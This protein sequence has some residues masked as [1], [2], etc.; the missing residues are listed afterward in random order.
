M[1]ALDTV[2][3]AFDRAFPAALNPWRNLGGVAFLLFWIVAAT[4]IYVYIGFD[5]QADGAYA[6]VERLADGALPLAALARS[7]HRYASD[8]F[9]LVV[10][11]HVVRECVRGRYRHFRRFSWIT[12]IVALW[13]AFASGLGGFWLVWDETAQYS[14]TATLEWLDAL[15]VFGGALVRNVLAG[16]AVSDR[17][18]SLLVFLHIG[19]PLTLLAAMWIHLLRVATP[20]SIAPRALTFGT[21][22]ALVVLAV[23]RPVTSAAPADMA[24]IPG[25][26]ALDWFYLGVHAFADATSP[27][28]LWAIAAGGTLLLL[29]L[30]WMTRVPRPAPARVDLSRC[31]G[32]A[33]C[34]DDC[35][36]LAITMAPRSD[37]RSL[38]A[39]AVVAGDLCAACGICAGSCSS[40]GIDLPD[41]PIARVRTELDA[42]LA[43]LRVSTADGARVI[44]FGCPTQRGGADLAHFGDERTATVALECAGQLP[45]SLVD[46]ALRAGADGVVVAGCRGGD[47]EFRLGNQWAE[48]RVTRRRAPKVRRGAWPSRVRTAW[49]GRGGESALRVA[50]AEF[51]TDL[52]LRSPQ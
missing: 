38:P 3:I 39:Q 10:V 16:G 37:G 48:A 14:F 49:A 5:T 31:N 12:G 26:I 50:L 2:E 27:A 20:R 13:L 35:P 45:A 22:A 51:R 11:L 40:T 19:I 42:A 7:L 18:F 1:N 9:I 23:A 47:C 44:V 6:S 17:L 36:Y 4:G 52:D 33:R 34:V 41:A 15:P 32:C 29:G 43:R 30:P 24:A 28:A 8:A 25:A 46:H 21:L